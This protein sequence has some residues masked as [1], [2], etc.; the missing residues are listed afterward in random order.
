MHFVRAFSLIVAAALLP[1]ACSPST[2]SGPEPVTVVETRTSMDPAARGDA[3][4]QRTMMQVHND[5]RSHVGPPSLQWD[6]MLAAD[7]AAYAAKLARSGRF[8]HDPQSGAGER[9]GENLWKG[10]KDAYRHDEMAGGWVDER[11]YF[12]RG[13]FPD[14]STTGRWGDVGHYTQIIWPTTRRFGCAMA[15]NARDDYLVC[16]YLPAGNVVGRDPL[17]G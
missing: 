17:K 11:R 1:A 15:S 8:E 6:A 4:L 10:T 16:R 7:A 5:A 14:N 13:L 12:K 3:L 2:S 9:Q